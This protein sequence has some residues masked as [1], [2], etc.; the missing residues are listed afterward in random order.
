MNLLVIGIS[1]E[2]LKLLVI[3]CWHCASLVIVHV[4]CSDSEFSS[5]NQRPDFS[6]MQSDCHSRWRLSLASSSRSF[7]FFCLNHP[8][9]TL[10]F[11]AH[12]W[13][14]SSFSV[15][16]HNLGERETKRDGVNNA[17]FRAQASSW[18]RSWLSVTAPL[19][20]VD[21]LSLSLSACVGGKT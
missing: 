12:V 10:M 4:K 19:G 15:S 16:S 14:I 17:P 11:A 20:A 2:K 9:V 18:W 8:H 5:E 3:N 6:S 1:H 13:N 7:Q 21:R